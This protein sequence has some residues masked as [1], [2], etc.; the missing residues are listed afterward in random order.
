VFVVAG[1][2]YADTCYL[3]TTQGCGNVDLNQL[4]VSVGVGVIWYS[5]MEPLSFSLAAPLKKPDNTETQIIQ[6]SLGQT[7]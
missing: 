4:A 5:P 3:S 7:F 2:V 1:N 6:F